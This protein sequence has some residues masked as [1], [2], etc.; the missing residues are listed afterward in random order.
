MSETPKWQVSY[1]WTQ[2][3]T[4][5]LNPYYNTLT[6]AHELQRLD[7]IDRAVQNM[8]TY[9]DAEAIINKLTKA[10]KE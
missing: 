8:L 2:P 10:N 1:T 4:V 3:Y 6:L 7:D 5:S 9:P